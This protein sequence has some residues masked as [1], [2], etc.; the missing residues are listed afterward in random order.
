M[1]QASEQYLPGKL[2]RIFAGAAGQPVEGEA[3]RGSRI[4]ERAP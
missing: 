3:C 2:L 1:L 4:I